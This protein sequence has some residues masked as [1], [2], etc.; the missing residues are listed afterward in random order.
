MI[1]VVTG[2]TESLLR[3]SVAATRAEHTSRIAIDVTLASDS[4]PVAQSEGVVDFVARR[5]RLENLPS[6]TV[7]AELTE[8]A[9]ASG[10]SQPPIEDASDLGSVS[11]FVGDVVYECANRSEQ[12]V[13]DEPGWWERPLWPLDV[14]AAVTDAR[15]V[16]A[17][18]VRGHPTTEYSGRLDRSTWRRLQSG[19]T[20]R[21]ML[22][23]FSRHELAMR[24]W[25]DGRGR[26]VRIRW[27]IVPAR[28]R[29]S[30]ISWT[31]TEFWDFGIPVDVEPPNEQPT[32]PP[33]TTRE[34]VRYLRA[35]RRQAD[36]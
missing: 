36:R 10:G 13:E 9:A 6:E 16:A 23:R 15:V 8:L 27:A 28:L 22:G 21:Q 30:D 2:H 5:L 29:A 26:A 7:R 24:V 31:T 11:V 35:T 4:S 25:L 34:I 32:S 19:I 17:D 3:A 18:E 14:L 33:S 20:P 12:W 1:A